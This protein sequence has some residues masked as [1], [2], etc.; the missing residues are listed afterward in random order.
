MQYTNKQLELTQ[1]LPTL[2]RILPQTKNK[3]LSSPILSQIVSL[4]LIPAYVLSTLS[5]SKIF[6]LNISGLNH[7]PPTHVFT[8]TLSVSIGEKQLPPT[9]TTHYLREEPAETHSIK[10]MN[11][12]LDNLEFSPAKPEVRKMKGIKTL[13]N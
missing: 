7:H 3:E 6:F 2:L 13:S 5:S 10:E 4:P 1:P 12:K 8:F 9:E 11:L